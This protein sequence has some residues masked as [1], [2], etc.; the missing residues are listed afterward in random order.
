MTR[1]IGTFISRRSNKV[2]Q[3]V[4]NEISRY[5]E[6]LSLLDVNLTHREIRT[7]IIERFGVTIGESTVSAERQN[8]GF[9]FCHPMFEQNLKWQQ[10][11]A[12]L[13]FALDLVRIGLTRKRSSFQMRVVL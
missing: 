6:T 7:K 5:I 10:R 1:K 13:Q 12:R 2:P 11:H 8:L 9:Y 4:T 3:K